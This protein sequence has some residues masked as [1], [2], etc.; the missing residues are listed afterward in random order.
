MRRKRSNFLRLEQIGF[1]KCKPHTHEQESKG[2]SVALRAL[3]INVRE[4]VRRIVNENNKIKMNVPLR[5]GF[6]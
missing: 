3:A 1:K 6:Q 5:G 4:D 2:R